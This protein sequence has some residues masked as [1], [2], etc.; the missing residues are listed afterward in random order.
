MT[1]TLSVL[2]L[3]PAAFNEIHAKLKEAGYDHAILEEPR[4]STL[5]DMSGIGVVIEGFPV[6]VV[7]P[8]CSKCLGDR[9]DY[10]CGS[11][12]T[13]S[14]CLGGVCATSCA[15]LGL[16]CGPHPVLGLECGTCPDGQVCGAVTVGQC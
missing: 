10:G 12:P 2:E 4:E 7:L 16:E 11:C 8:P 14:E 1:H 13:G 6:A 3:S 5:I 15:S 9:A